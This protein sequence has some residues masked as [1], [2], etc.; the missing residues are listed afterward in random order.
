[1]KPVRWSSHALKN[2]TDREIPREEA[3]RTLSNPELILPARPPRRFLMR[4]YFHEG[5][6]QEMLLRALVEDTPSEQIVITVYITSKLG[7]YMK[8]M[9]L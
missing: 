5:L 7:K 1:L 9:A 2:L 3:E 8:G 4:R 6:E